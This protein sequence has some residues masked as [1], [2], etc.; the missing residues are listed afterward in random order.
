MHKRNGDTLIEVT[1]AVGIFSLVAIAVVAVV[2]GSTSGAQT[3]LETTLAREEIDTQA[4]ALRFIQSSYINSDTADEAVI[5]PPSDP[6]YQKFKYRLLWEK[7]ESYAKK[8]QNINGGNLNYRP[9]TCQELYE[10]KEGSDGSNQ[11]QREG[12]IVINPQKLGINAS[13]NFEDE[14]I[15]STKTKNNLQKFTEASTY[16]HIIYGS[17]DAEAS[18]A[19]NISGQGIYQVE[20]LYVIAVEGPQTAIVIN[21]KGT[22]EN[23]TVAA[24]YDFYIRSC[25]YESGATQPTTVSTLMRLYNPRVVK[26]Y[27]KPKD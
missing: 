11:I 5:P 2:N 8:P 24:Y 16:P 18:L 25:W 15:I 19:D 12:A 21:E 27:P 14:I 26:L 6:E 17:T 4:E 3:A 20:G 23:K 10:I 1:L 9:N 7:I 13:K 22:I